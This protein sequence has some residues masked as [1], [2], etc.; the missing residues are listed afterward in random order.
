MRSESDGSGL[1]ILGAFA[2]GAALMYFLDPGRGARRRAVARDKAV[3]ALHKTG[4]AAETTGRDL[5]NRAQGLVAEIRGRFQ[6]EDVDDDVL[7]ARVRAAM[8]RTIS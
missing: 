2:A 7:V 1:G 8:G 6:R 4:D 5:R 3:H